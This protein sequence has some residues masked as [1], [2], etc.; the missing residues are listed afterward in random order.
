M[1]KNT[2][3]MT[4]G[5]KHLGAGR[6]KAGSEYI[7]LQLAAGDLM[8]QCA[9]LLA[10]GERRM[11]SIVVARRRQPSLRGST[12]MV[13]TYVQATPEEEREAEHAAVAD[14]QE[15]EV[16]AWDEANA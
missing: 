10:T 4:I 7:I 9:E 15:R 13:Y 8:Q 3:T 11:I 14:R 2:N 6:Q 1:S 16:R 12:H 5:K